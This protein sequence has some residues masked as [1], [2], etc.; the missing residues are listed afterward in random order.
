M[1]LLKALL[2]F[3][4]LSCVVHAEIKT[5]IASYY[6]DWGTTYSDSIAEVNTL[7]HHGWRIIEVRDEHRTLYF[8]LQSPDAV[9]TL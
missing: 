5:V 9:K 8:V 4:L 1:K 7:I 6:Y 3:L 2:L